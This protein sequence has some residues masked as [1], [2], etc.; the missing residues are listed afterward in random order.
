MLHIHSVPQGVGPLGYTQIALQ[1]LAT[2]GSYDAT[3]GPDSSST[4]SEQRV[5]PS[6]GGSKPIASVVLVAS[7]ISFANM[8]VIF[9]TIGSI[10]DYG[11][12][13]RWLLFTVTLVCWAT[14][15]ACM[16]LTCMCLFD[17]GVVEH[18]TMSSS[19]WDSILSDSFPTPQPW[20]LR[21]C[22]P[23]SRPEYLSLSQST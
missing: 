2:S 21:C 5:L 23:P 13:A 3:V 9:T 7:G 8:T 18:S 22:I 16:A 1:S 11:I 10:A 4:A 6:L 20:F 14:Q 17:V 19:S 12:F 15:E